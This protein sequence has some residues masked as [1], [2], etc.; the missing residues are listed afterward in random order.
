MSH[1][2]SYEMAIR[3]T[4]DI[5]D[6]TVPSEDNY[7]PGST[8]ASLFISGLML[9][10]CIVCCKAGR[11]VCECMKS[12][13][14][15]A[16][17]CTCCDNVS[18]DCSV[19]LKRIHQ[20]REALASR[21]REYWEGDRRNSRN[22][23]HTEA[24]P[25][26]TSSPDRLLLDDHSIHSSLNED[27]SHPS[28]THIPPP[29]Y[30]SVVPASSHPPPSY[31]EFL[32]MDGGSTTSYTNIR[33]LSPDSIILSHT[34]YESEDAISYQHAYSIQEIPALFDSIVNNPPQPPPSYEDFQLM[35]NSSTTSND[36]TRAPSSFSDPLPPTDNSFPNADSSHRAYSTH[37]P[38][39]PSYDSIVT[40]PTLPPPSYD[41]VFGV[42]V[43]SITS[44]ANIRRSPISS[45]SSPVNDRFIDSFVNEDDS[46]TSVTLGPPLFFQYTTV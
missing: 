29:S 31:E 6:V 42:G 36:A 26:I 37:D 22:N 3:T 30:G 24:P 32:R 38:P 10:I 4:T 28:P 14:L 7:D 45:P 35:D 13:L 23:A 40:D 39:P 19:C 46:R 25:T 2:I 9:F 21:V 5:S 11:N 44:N 12:F 41:E 16:V 33:S 34:D 8:L 17:R 27:Y 43:S 1:L 20:G 18:C 15:D